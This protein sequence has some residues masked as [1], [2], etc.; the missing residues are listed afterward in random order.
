MFYGASGQYFFSGICF[1]SQSGEI[2]QI[3]RPKKI[4]DHPWENIAKSGY[5]P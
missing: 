1:C 2:I 3:G 4:G 5:K